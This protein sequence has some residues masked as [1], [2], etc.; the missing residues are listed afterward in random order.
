[1]HFQ[2]TFMVPGEAPVSPGTI[3]IH[4]ILEIEYCFI[5]R[6][7]ICI[8]GNKLADGAC[9]DLR[10]CSREGL[11][12]ALVGPSWVIGESQ[13]RVPEIGIL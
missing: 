10:T 6:A 11:S 13:L 3:N 7:R 4:T 12:V 1:M 9:L 5:N 8:D 2:R